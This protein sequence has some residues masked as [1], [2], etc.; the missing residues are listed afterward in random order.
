MSLSQ[1]SEPYTEMASVVIAPL[2][3][4]VGAAD[5]NARATRGLRGY[6]LHGALA[7]HALDEAVA[8]YGGV[9]SLT[10][11][12]R[13]WSARRLTRSSRILRAPQ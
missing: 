3:M 13:T 12:M 9:D 1:A 6:Q 2:S 11:G 4:R 5:L 10:A 8:I 7:T